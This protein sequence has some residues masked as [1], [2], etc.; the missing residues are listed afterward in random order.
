MAE[1]C[2]PGHRPRPRP[3]DASV[4]L[5]SR[6]PVLPGDAVFQEALNGRAGAVSDR[7]VRQRTDDQ[8]KS[9]HDSSDRAFG[10]PDVT[11]WRHP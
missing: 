11:H 3:V 2:G 4:I 10:Q 7:R 6:R 8:S 5:K 9:S 1:L